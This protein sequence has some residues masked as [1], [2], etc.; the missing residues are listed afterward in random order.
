MVWKE[1]FWAARSQVA[2]STPRSQVARHRL[3]KTKDC[4]PRRTSSEQER[5]IAKERTRTQTHERREKKN[6]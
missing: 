4:R 1:D 5:E 3:E 2:R 6:K